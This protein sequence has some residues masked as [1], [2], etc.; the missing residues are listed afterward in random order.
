LALPA[1]RIRVTADWLLGSLMRRQAVQL[2]LLGAASV[3][4][5]TNKPEVPKNV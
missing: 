4:L 5:E 1:N 3:P 2:G